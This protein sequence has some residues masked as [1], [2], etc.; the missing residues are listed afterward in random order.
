MQILEQ[1]KFIDDRKKA[2]KTLDEAFTALT[3]MEIN[4]E[5]DAFKDTRLQAMREVA[6]YQQNLRELKQEKEREEKILGELVEQYRQMVLKK[7]EDAQCKII[8][9]KIELKKVRLDNIQSHAFNLLSFSERYGRQSGTN[10]AEART[11]G[12]GIKIQTGRK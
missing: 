7:Q 11:R 5:R 2:E 4:R 1:Q 8:A 9:A 10:K 12:T 3:E 6:M